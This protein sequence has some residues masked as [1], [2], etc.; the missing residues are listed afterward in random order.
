M[1]A[2]AEQ[3]RTRPIVSDVLPT[4]L[5]VAIDE[6]AIHAPRENASP[7]VA[8]IDVIRDLRRHGSLHGR[9]AVADIEQFGI[10]CR[11]L[12]RRRVD[13]ELA[14]ARLTGGLPASAARRDDDLR[15]R[16]PH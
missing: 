1:V 5:V 9:R 12:E 7:A 14:V 6:D 8:R 16:F 3:K 10:A 4:A 13:L 2:R 11:L 15:P